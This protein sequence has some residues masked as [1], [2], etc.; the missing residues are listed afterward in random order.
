MRLPSI[1]AAFVLL[2]AAAPAFADI[3]FPQP[4]TAVWTDV[5]GGLGLGANF[6]F[7][8]T[9]PNSLGASDGAKE[10]VQFNNAVTAMTFTALLSFNGVSP[11]GNPTIV[12]HRVFVSDATEFQ[13]TGAQWQ[14]GGGG[15]ATLSLAPIALTNSSYF[16]TGSENEANYSTAGGFSFSNFNSLLLT[17]TYTPNGGSNPHTLLLDAVSNPEPGTMALFGLGALGL[18][19]VAWRRRRA[20]KAKKAAEASVA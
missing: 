15:T 5:T 11:V 13:L 4:T 19:G 20:A 2:G 6:V 1:A 8:P 16:L 12:L 14:D 10:G 9:G 3:A 18:G 7:S 17:F